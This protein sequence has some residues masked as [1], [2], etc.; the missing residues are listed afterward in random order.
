MRYFPIKL[1][2]GALLS[3]VFLWTIING[4]PV[5]RIHGTHDE[6]MVLIIGVPS[7]LLF[8][9]LGFVIPAIRIGMARNFVV[10]AMN[11]KL[12]SVCMLV[13]GGI[14]L[15]FACHYGLVMSSISG[16]LLTVGTGMWAG[17]AWSLRRRVRM[18]DK[19]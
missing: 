3:T 15:V 6:L 5:V 17:T 1:L 19:K 16:W 11:Y 7:V 12:S 13:T 10:P 8:F 4:M 14:G 9:I 2:F 18:S